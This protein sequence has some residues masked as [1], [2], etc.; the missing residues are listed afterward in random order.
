M[1]TSRRLR[2][3]RA[4]GGGALAALA[5]G[6][7]GH[8][9]AERRD[10]QLAVTVWSGGAG[11]QG[12][13]GQVAV[14]AGPSAAFV[15][16]R[17]DVEVSA[18][19]EARFPGVAATIDPATVEV[20]SL[21]EPGAA[22]VEQRLLGDRARPDEL[23]ARQIGRPI[24]VTFE[25][26]EVRGVLRAVS[27][28]FLAI[29]TDGAGGK[30]LEL[31]RRGDH[32]LDIKL[33]AVDVATE[34]TLQW[35]LAGARPGTHGLEVSYHAEGLRWT[36]AY[37]AVLA[38]DDAVDFGAWATI[39]NRSG[40]DLEGARVTLMVADPARPAA[41]A[42]A[43]KLP[44]PVNLTADH[45]LQVELAPR[46]AGVRGRRVTVFE[47]AADLSPGYA[48]VPAADCY[49][50]APAGGRAELAL[51][52]DGAGP[53]LPPGRL[54]VLRRSGGET[55]LARDEQLRVDR[56]SGTIRIK[57]DDT[58]QITGDRKQEK[59]ESGPT[60]RSLRE[61]IEVTVENRGKAAADVVIRE[62]MFR[63][64]TWEIVSEDVKGVRTDS[65][66]QEYRVR[67]APGGRRTV[68]YAV[69]YTW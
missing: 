45:D 27:F 36:P 17:R 39:A 31:V 61:D 20:R 25:R 24:T 60:G 66:A 14:P 35:T 64:R 55:V 41:A 48:A 3:A 10:S 37:T 16:H 68:R 13:G 28:A 30:G 23:L 67:L 63:W 6:L 8:A 43:F 32:L 15:V 34:P 40:L 18:S 29:E 21:T 53:A 42:T 38:D 50:Y 12:Y 19:G 57:L 22:V 54:R 47:A 65:Q 58:E 7:A 51:E 49:G 56:G 69:V 2:G 4:L 46:R 11:G 44:R 26:G 1:T 33:G 9:L 59:C 62:Y 5:V 52:L